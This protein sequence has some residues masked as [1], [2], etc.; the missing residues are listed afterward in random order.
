MSRKKKSEMNKVTDER[1]CG[2]CKHFLYEDTDGYGYCEVNTH[3]PES[4][5][6]DVCQAFKSR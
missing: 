1:C 3:K 6:S 5:C 4:H 2:C